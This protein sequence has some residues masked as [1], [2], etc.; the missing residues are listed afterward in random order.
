M[1]EDFFKDL[2]YVKM[3]DGTYSSYKWSESKGYFTTM[4]NNVE[5]PSGSSTYESFADFNTAKETKKGI[6]G[7]LTDNF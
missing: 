3:D 4:E 1:N 5:P 2:H 7:E 6:C